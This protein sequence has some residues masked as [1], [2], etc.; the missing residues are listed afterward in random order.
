MI[1]KFKIVI[2]IGITL[3][4]GCSN[5]D[6][7]EP[8]ELVQQSTEV[9]SDISLSGIN[10]ISVENSKGGIIIYGTTIKETLSYT[11]SKTIKAESKDIAQAHFDEIE[12]ETNTIDDLLNFSVKYPSDSER[13]ESYGYLDMDISRDIPCTISNMREGVYSLYMSNTLTIKNIKNHIEITG[14][15]GSCDLETEKGL[16]EIEIAIPDSG[17]CKA[18]TLDGDIILNI[19]TATSATISAATESGTVTY[20]NLTISNLSQEEG[21][22]SGA[23]GSGSGEIV[24]STKKGNISITG[25]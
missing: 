12:L 20:K 7:T 9:T 3:I 11:L 18:I 16:I 4:L 14:H 13:L 25:I 23:V 19:P 2:L 21:K 10:K 17:F 22:L 8:V 24:L 15:N 1:I 5:S 6:T